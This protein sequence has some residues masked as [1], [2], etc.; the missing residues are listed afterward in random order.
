MSKL[1]MTNLTTMN[2]TLTTPMMITSVIIVTK[3]IT[4]ITQLILAV[5]QVNNAFTIVM[6]GMGDE[7]FHPDRGK[8]YVKIVMTVVGHV[9]MIITVVEGEECPVIKGIGKHTTSTKGGDYPSVKKCV[10]LN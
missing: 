4:V 7:I 3:I 8:A 1:A 9:V 6:K 10:Q 5:D 2:T